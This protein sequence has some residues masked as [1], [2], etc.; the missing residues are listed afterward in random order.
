[1]KIQK[2]SRICMC[3][4]LAIML[5]ALVMSL[6]GH[7]INYGLDF[8][9]GLTLQFNLDADTAVALDM[10]DVTA[11]VAAQGIT[12]SNVTISGEGALRISVPAL[13]TDDEIQQLQEGLK[14]A[15]ADKY[16]AIADAT[17]T[18][19]YVGPIAGQT[20]VKNAIWSVVIAAALMLV[21]IALRF[22]LFSGIAAVVGLLHDVLIMLSFMVLLRSVIQMNS[23][24][25]AAMLTIVGYS[26]NN[27]IVIFDRIRE[28]N[29]KP[30]YAG[31]KRED[32]VQ[33]SVKESL[34]RTI[35]TTLTTLVTIVALY[36]LGVDAIRQFSLPII[37]GILAGVY[38]ANLINGYVWAALE[39]ARLARKN[40]A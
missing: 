21:Y 39:E 4:S 2:R 14:A 34:G 12:E 27:T 31:L 33:K 30:A 38:S 13:N 40:K 3:I 25:I 37:I 36:V 6:T 32:V 10:A 5:I 26:I 18:A 20:L 24:F 29:K 1:M 35:N 11:A 17:A 15:L 16:P 8:A 22:D 9:G 7:G 28:N 19:S 23:S